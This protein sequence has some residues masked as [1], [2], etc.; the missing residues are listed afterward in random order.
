MKWIF[1]Q[2][3]L[4]G[5]I[6]NIFFKHENV[7]IEELFFN[8][9]QNDITLIKTIQT[10]AC[11]IRV[12]IQREIA[13][14]LFMYNNI[15]YIC[16]LIKSSTFGLLINKVTISQTCLWRGTQEDTTINVYH[17]QR[18]DIPSSIEKGHSIQIKIFFLPDT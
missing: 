4:W 3:R 12:H 16:I 1:F 18:M 5:S 14:K 2:I 6:L 10:C 15:T 7:T 13:V 8:F 11:L 17:L 9:I